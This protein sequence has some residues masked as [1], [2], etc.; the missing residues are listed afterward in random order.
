MIGHVFQAGQIVHRQELVDVRQSGLN[1]A[2]QRFIL[3]RAKERIQP[4]D[5]VTAPF[6]TC[7]LAV[8]QVHVA[9]DEYHR[10]RPSARRPHSKLKNL[11]DFPIRVA[12][13]QTISTESLFEKLLQ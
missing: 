6:Q 11:I 5:A 3:R 13:L 2:C 4:Y 9:D 10:T 8:K 7:H 1:A 12:A